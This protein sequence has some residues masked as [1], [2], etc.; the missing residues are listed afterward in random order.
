M[1]RRAIRARDRDI[2]RA[3]DV[4]RDIAGNLASARDIAEAVDLDLEL[5]SGITAELQ[6]VSS[7]AN[8]TVRELAT[9][10]DLTT[11]LKKT[12]IL[13]AALLAVGDCDLDLDSEIDISLALTITGARSDAIA[14]AGR[15]DVIRSDDVADQMRGNCAVRV[16]VLLAGVAA[17]LLPTGGHARY[18]EEYRSELHELAAAGNPRRSQVRY[19]LRLLQTAL[20]LRIELRDP[21]RR[22]AGP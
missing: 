11:A 10:S 17:R 2:A 21:L 6:F 9:A 7:I 12:R 5:V 14:L 16:A 18:A 20:P 22:K 3:Q 1:S 4:A 19:A 8:G 15:L 13:A